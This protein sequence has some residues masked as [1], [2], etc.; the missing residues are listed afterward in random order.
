M[1]AVEPVSEGAVRVS[2]GPEY[3][4]R[5]RVQAARLAQRG[6]SGTPVRHRLAIIQ[7]LRLRLANEALTASNSAS[8]RHRDEA[9]K[10]AAEVLPVLEALA[11]LEREAPRLLRRTRLGRRGRPSW[12][13]GLVARIERRPLGV[14]LIVAPGNYPFLLMAIQVAQALVAGNTV[15]VKPAPDGVEAAEDFHHRLI[16]AGLP[17]DAFLL[18]DPDPSSVHDCLAEGVDHLIFT[19]STKAGHQVH[20]ACAAAGVPSTAEWSGCDA[21]I[22]SEQ[23]QGDSE[24]RH[25]ARA[26]AF[27]LSLNRG[28]S[29]IA[30][31]RVYGSV[32]TLDRFVAMLEDELGMRG[33]EIPSEERDAL[34]SLA[35]RAE[36]AGARPILNE[37]PADRA[38]IAYDCSGLDELRHWPAVDSHDAPAGMILGT[39]AVEN[40]REAIARVNEHP[41]RLGASVFGPGAQAI[42]EQLEVGFVSVGDV[43]LGSADP[44]LPFGGRAGSGFGVTRGAEGLLELTTPRATSIR[45]RGPLRHLELP[46]EGDA[47]LLTAL[48][49]MDHAPNPLG[50]LR[51]LGDLIRAIKNRGQF[52][53]TTSAN[54]SHD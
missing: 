26:V 54:E 49:R 35:V 52:S 34:G 53:P 23:I 14:V 47:A 42:A 40:D 4:S 16:E 50:R 21:V 22:L 17:S 12:L 10:V 41:F 9:A 29:C 30:P 43:I 15:L 44:R 39:F 11:F 45:R 6:W 19:G 24:L 18:L 3:S 5:G 7:K 48:A 33:T 13:G 20:A 31:R 25:A 36:R 51:A 46:C 37:L 27:G 8:G 2:S 32:A 28:H 38:P 1:T